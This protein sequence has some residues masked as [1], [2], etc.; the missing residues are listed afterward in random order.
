MRGFWC[1]GPVIVALVVWPASDRSLKVVT[2]DNTL[3]LGRAR[4]GMA[5]PVQRQES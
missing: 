2:D 1:L 3:E 5:S 4:G